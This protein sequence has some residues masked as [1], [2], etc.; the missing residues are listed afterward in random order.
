MDPDLSMSTFIDFMKSAKANGSMFHILKNN[1]QILTQLSQ[2]FSF[3]PYTGNLLIQRPELL[4]SFV[5][6]T[7][8]LNRPQTDVDQYVQN[9]L[10][11]KQLNHLVAIG[12]FLNDLDVQKFCRNLS[13]CA[14]L[15]ARSILKY[16]SNEFS[17]KNIHILALGNGA[18]MNWASTLT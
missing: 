13:Q 15:I 18:V 11:F 1:P 3:S 16:F 14:D 8:E 9:L 2:L 4:D 7:V 5:L 12:Y 17:T 10:D 6:G